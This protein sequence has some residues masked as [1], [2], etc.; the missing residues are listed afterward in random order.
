[1]ASLLG[2]SCGCS[3]CNNTTKMRRLLAGGQRW[4]EM[5]NEDRVSHPVSANAGNLP[6]DLPPCPMANPLIT[7]VCPPPRWSSCPLRSSLSSLQHGVACIVLPMKLQHCYCHWQA[8]E[9]AAITICSGPGG[10]EWGSP[11]AAVIM[12]SG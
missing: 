8:E 12:C 6:P 4:Q 5:R 2:G 11:G 3:S 10:Q 9:E 7:A 1:M